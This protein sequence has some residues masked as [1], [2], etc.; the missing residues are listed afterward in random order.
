MEK[1][2]AAEIT[3]CRI[4]HHGLVD[5]GDVHGIHVGC[6][7]TQRK[8]GRGK[9][10]QRQ[11]Y[12]EGCGGFHHITNITIILVN[13]TKTKNKFPLKIFLSTAVV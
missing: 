8:C 10:N 1:L 3:E 6:M 11:Q 13:K 4:V 9:Q 2:L 7:G 5:D 12:R